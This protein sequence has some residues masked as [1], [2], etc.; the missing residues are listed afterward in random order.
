M[1]A[2][3]TPHHNLY[4]LG[5]LSQPNRRGHHYWQLQDHPFALGDLVLLASCQQGLQHALDGFSG[6]CHQAGMKTSTKKRGMMSIQKP[7]LVFAAI[8]YRKWSSSSFWWYTRV[9]ENGTGTMTNGL[10]IQAQF[11]I[12]FI[13]LWSWFSN[14]V[15]RI[16]GNYHR[17][18]RIRE[19]RVPRIREIGSL[20][21]HTGY[22]TFS[23]K[24]PCSTVKKTTT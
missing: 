16:R 6:V 24:K 10:L 18:P 21:V 19:N 20:Q 11:C 3:T 9:T 23:L 8:H 17:V 14:R 15:P 12:S 2:V 4:E 7:T 13:A 22:R 5:G 1:C